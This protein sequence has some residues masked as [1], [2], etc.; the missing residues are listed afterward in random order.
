MPGS[1]PNDSDMKGKFGGLYA[2]K[3]VL[4]TGHTGFKGSWLC[5][6]LFGLG[7]KVTGYSLSPPTQPA[8]FEQLGLARRLRHIIGDIR[9]LPGL[10]RALRKARPDYVFR[11]AA[12]PLVRDFFANPVWTSPRPSS[13]RC[14]GIGKPPGSPNPA[15]PSPPGRFNSIPARPPRPAFAGRLNCS[16]CSPFFHE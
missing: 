11:L 7:A 3:R 8:L 9:D 2:G 5:E 16:R 6:W 4:V 13:R 1:T 10:S 14:N 15:R 12:Q